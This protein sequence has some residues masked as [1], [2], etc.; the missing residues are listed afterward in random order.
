MPN[1][2]DIAGDRFGRLTAI[3]RAVVDK[4]GTYWVVKCDCGAVAN[5]LYGNLV[6]GRQRSC[7]CLHRELVTGPNNFKFKHGKSRSRVHNIW[8]GMLNRCFNKNSGA[9]KRYGGR[10][11]SVCTEWLK[12]SKFY[13]DMGD[14]PMGLTL[15]RINN[16]EGYSLENCIW[17]DAKVQANNTRKS[18]N[19]QKLFI[20]DQY[21]RIKEAAELLNMSVSCLKHRLSRGWSMERI[22]SQPPRKVNRNERCQ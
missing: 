1:P 2:V 21:L 10:G 9:Y 18:N 13:A 6:S 8:L 17:A 20:N 12:F 7:G 3:E 19:S 16:E 14:P 11:I 4:P 22:I 5:V 15:E